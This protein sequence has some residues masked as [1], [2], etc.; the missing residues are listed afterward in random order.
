VAEYKYTHK[1]A[2]LSACGRYRYSLTR[3][4]SGGPCMLFVMFNPSTADAL[5]DDPT[6]RRC[7]SFAMRENYGSMEVVNCFAFRSPTPDALRMQTIDT[8][9]PDNRATVRAA[10]QRAGIVVCAWGAHPV[11]T[12]PVPTIVAEAERWC[13]GVTRDGSPRHPLYVRG[14]A[15]LIRWPTEVSS[16]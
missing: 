16:G 13:L 14:D 11:G 2:L 10:C 3:S 12:S 5:R 7:V 1:A 4:W 8:V 15:P 9:G 6:I